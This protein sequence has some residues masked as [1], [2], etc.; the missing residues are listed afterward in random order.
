MD[1]SVTMVAN[2]VYGAVRDVARARMVK[3][4]TGM[5]DDE[6][7]YTIAPFLETVDFSPYPVAN[8]VGPVVGELYGTG[9]PERAFTFGLT[10][11]LDG[12]ERLIGGKGQVDG[13]GTSA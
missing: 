13:G 5:S 7:W 11:L 2:Y 1:M 9:D 3:D 8:R 10:L 12:F 6:W 4:L